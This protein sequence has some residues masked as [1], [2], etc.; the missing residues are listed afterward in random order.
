VT[1]EVVY[2][3]IWLLPPLLVVCELPLRARPRPRPKAPWL[4]VGLLY[5]YLPSNCCTCNSKSKRVISHTGASGALPGSPFVGVAFGALEPYFAHNRWYLLVGFWVE[6]W[7]RITLP[8]CELVDIIK[9]KLCAIVQ[10]QQR[11]V[12]SHGRCR[13][14][15][16]NARCWFVWARDICALMQMHTSQTHLI[17]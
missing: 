4:W 17:F 13:E 9:G 3:L 2:E 11:W 15:Y 7:H 8:F 10:L 6:F 16:A 5:F 14:K 12:E 1:C